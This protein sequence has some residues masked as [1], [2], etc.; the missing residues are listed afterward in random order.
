MTP[1]TVCFGSKGNSFGSF[2]TPK[3]GHVITFKLIYQSGHIGCALWKTS[4]W[5]CSSII[6]PAGFKMGTHITDT[7]KK[8]LLPKDEFMKD[9]GSNY[10]TRRLYYNL[11]GIDI[12]SPV[13]LFD[14][15]STPLSVTSGTQFQIWFADDLGDCLEFDNDGGKTCVQ[16]FGLFL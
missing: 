8:R 3:S 7:Q 9:A 10:C 4:H 6:V 5:G 1:S 13:L 14:N 2:T 12:N 15:F 11:P 16:V